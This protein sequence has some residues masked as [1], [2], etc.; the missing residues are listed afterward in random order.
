MTKRLLVDLLTVHFTDGYGASNQV[1]LPLASGALA[2]KHGTFGS[3]LL[4]RSVTDIDGNWTQQIISAGK[5]PKNRVST[6]AICGTSSGVDLN[7]RWAFLVRGG[8]RQR[9]VR[10]PSTLISSHDRFVKY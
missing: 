9:T 6:A 8:M 4:R 7:R 5:R 2:Y 10:T 3:E 1:L